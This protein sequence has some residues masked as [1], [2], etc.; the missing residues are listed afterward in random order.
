MDVVII[1]Y[2][3]GNTQSVKIA[4]NR[5]GCNSIL[6][7]DKDKILKSDRVIFPGV[8]EASS[9]MKKLKSIQLHRLIPDL[10]QPVLGICLGM[11]LMCD[12]S[13]EGD[14]ECLG[15]FKASVKRFDNKLKT[16][17]VGWNTISSLKT[18]LFNGV[19]ENEY[20]YLLHSY[21]V[22]IIKETISCS[23]YGLQYS[24]AIKKN[25]FTGLQFHPEKSSEFGEVVLNNF[26]NN[27]K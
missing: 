6:S 27:K 14:T 13:E 12:Y 25:N 3:A 9:A 17:Q 23:S 26:L 19:K 15:I 10:K 5:L 18:S 1:D 2:G 11:Q 8:G 22:P 20:M 7:S 16:P 4:L 21:Y 24:T